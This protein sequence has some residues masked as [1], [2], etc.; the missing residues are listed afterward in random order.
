M[1]PILL[2][3][4]VAVAIII[5]K[6]IVLMRAE[7]DPKPLLLKIRTS[8]SNN[9][10]NG[11]VE[12]CAAVKA[13]IGA[14]MKRG[15]AQYPKG[16]TAVREAIENAGKE[17]VFQLEKRL[18]LL[19][20]VAAVTPMLGFLGT[21]IGMVLAF[22][23]IEHMGGN[24]N[25]S[26]LASGIWQ[27]LLCSAFGLIVGIPAL[28]FYNY[29]VGRITRLVHDLEVVAE[30]FLQMVMKGEARASSAESG[31]KSSS[32]R[33]VFSDDEFFEPKAE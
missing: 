21:V 31:K 30:E 33:T 24:T 19:A 11:A 27:G 1:W 15:I 29:F 14:I 6:L 20:N 32:M 8:L 5:E 4:L 3:S 2:G 17:E 22:Q 10:V 28:F 7:I 25:A 13:P 18:G 23:A 26:V 16:L 9:D 12:A